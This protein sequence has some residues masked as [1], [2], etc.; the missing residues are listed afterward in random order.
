MIYDILNEF[1]LE[2]GS[3][4]KIDVLKKYKDN[5]LLTKVLVMA[6]DKV[7]YTYGISNKNVD[8][9]PGNKRASD[10]TLNEALD[11]IETKFCTR[12]I[13]GNNAIFNLEAL[14]EYLSKEDADVLY[15]IINR[16]LKINL[17]RTNINKVH[18]NLI[19]KPPYMRCDIGTK[20]NV[21]KNIDFNNIV[22]SQVKM[23]GTYRSA[24][25]EDEITIMSRS[26]HEDTF[27]LI[28][29]E[30]K[31][32]KSVLPDV[33][34]TGELTLKGEQQRNK[35]NGII[36]SHN[37]LHE[38]IIFTVW[39]AIPLNEYTQKNGTS[40]YIDRLSKLKMALA[41]FNLEYVKLIEYKVIKNMKEAYQD[42][43]L[44]T[45]NGGEGTVIK[46]YDMTWKDGTSKKQLKVKLEIMLDMRC[47]GFTDGT[48]GTKREKT[49]GAM[50][51]EN[52]EGTIKGQCSGFTDKELEEISSDKESYIGRVF[53]IKCNDITKAKDND[54][55]ALIHGNFVG[56][57]DKDDTDTLERSLELKELAMELK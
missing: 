6:Y 9:R 56:F 29:K 1:N 8:Y 44:V 34:L 41:Q 42:F 27:P 47:T 2:N 46:S 54:Y 19:V 32:I 50:K 22:Y 37:P 11:F 38:D 24:V 13:T 53:E 25:L 45:K 28:E 14:Y 3:N 49:F 52:D 26:G 12:E 35:G 17:G 48:K 7:T 15:R 51:F 21:D 30:L 20:K 55:Y 57:R 39:D 36:N 4:Y 31:L 43:Q 40:L 10:F 23:D 18:K 33:V 5:K 16:D